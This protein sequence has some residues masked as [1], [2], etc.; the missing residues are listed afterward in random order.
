MNSKPAGSLLDRV[1]ELEQE[2]A[3]YRDCEVPNWIAECEME[4]ERAEAAEREVERLKALV[5]RWIHVGPFWQ[6]PEKYIWVGA[7]KDGNYKLVVLVD[8]LPPPPSSTQDGHDNNAQQG[9]GYG[10]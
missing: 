7:R 4:T 6:E 3:N 2:L 5:P 9:E 10:E 8:N 1:A